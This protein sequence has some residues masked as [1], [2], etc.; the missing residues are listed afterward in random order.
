MRQSPPVARSLLALAVGGVS[1]ALLGA[2]CGGTK[3]FSLAKTKQCLAG[4]KGVRLTHHVDFVADT[5]LGGAVVV[6][7]PSRNQVTMAF[8]LDQKEADRLAGAYR[9]FHGKNIGIE[10]VLRPD[11]NAVLLWKQ[12]PSEKDISTVNGCLR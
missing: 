2:G 7:L 4:E 5:A 9:R 6:K 12:H 10:D 8:A 11:H 1:L 3:S